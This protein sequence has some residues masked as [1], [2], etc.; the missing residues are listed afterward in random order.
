MQNFV[1][2]IARMF[3]NHHLGSPLTFLL[4]ILYIYPYSTSGKI[5]VFSYLFNKLNFVLYN[6]RDIR[7]KNKELFQ[8]IQKLRNITE[9]I[10]I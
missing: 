4:K 2:L 7:N 6:L 1:M 5:S 10:F 9:F 8:R 3:K